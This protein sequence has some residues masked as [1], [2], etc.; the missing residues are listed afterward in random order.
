M[1]EVVM[2][3]GYGSVRRFNDHIKQ[4]YGR[5]PGTLRKR[6]TTN[7]TGGLVITLPYREPF[8]FNALLTFFAARAI[9]S[10]EQ[11]TGDE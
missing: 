7:Q 11:V 8:D 4:V 10:V 2:A 1:I 3:A 5:A 6:S 9:P